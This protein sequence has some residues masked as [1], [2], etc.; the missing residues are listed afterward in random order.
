M[1][2]QSLWDHVIVLVI[3]ISSVALPADRPNILFIAVDDLN[4][5][6]HCMGGHPQARTPHNRLKVYRIM[7]IIVFFILLGLGIHSVDVLMCIAFSGC[8]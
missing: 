2:R 6:V 4:D 3:G 5:W 8:S 7:L 1:N